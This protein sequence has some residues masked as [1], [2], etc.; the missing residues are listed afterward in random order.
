MEFHRWKSV[1]KGRMIAIILH[2]QF[3]IHLSAHQFKK[4]LN[5]IHFICSLRTSFPLK[6]MAQQFDGKRPQGIEVNSLIVS[7]FIQRR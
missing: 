1:Y 4:E 7:I 6:T 5:C 2:P 3:H